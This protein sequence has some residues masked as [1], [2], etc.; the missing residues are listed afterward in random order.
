MQGAECP[1]EIPQC[2]HGTAKAPTAAEVIRADGQL[3]A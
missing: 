1:H 2:V 3:S